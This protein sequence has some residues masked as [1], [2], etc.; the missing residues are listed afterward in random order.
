MVQPSRTLLAFAP[1]A[2]ALNPVLI[3]ATQPRPHVRTPPRPDPHQNYEDREAL[4][5]L[6]DYLTDSAV[7]LLRQTFCEIAEPLCSG[8]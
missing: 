1:F 3:C 4:N 5:V 6:I 8:P 2:L 7:S